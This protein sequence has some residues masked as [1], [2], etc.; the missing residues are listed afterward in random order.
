M[1]EKPAEKIARRRN[2]PIKIH[3]DGS[4]SWPC[5]IIFDNGRA[6][7]L[8][9]YIRAGSVIERNKLLVKDYGVGQGH[10]SME[11]WNT[12]IVMD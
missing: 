10:A 2:C 9:K 11:T 1:R 3:N 6:P 12:G 8:S 7:L 5:D 4:T